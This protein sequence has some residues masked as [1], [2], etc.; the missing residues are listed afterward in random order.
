MVCARTATY[1]CE[2]FDKPC[3]LARV[4]DGCGRLWN[5]HFDIACERDNPAG[6]GHR[7]VCND[8]RCLSGW[9]RLV[10]R[11]V[12][13]SLSNN[14]GQNELIAPLRKCSKC[15]ACDF[16]RVCARAR[17]SPLTHH[18]PFNVA[19][20]LADADASSPGSPLCVRR[21]SQGSQNH[22]RALPPQ[23][24]PTDRLTF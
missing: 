18:P 20:V 15:V 2:L 19:S 21:G 22:H 6:H 5:T 24:P 13:A 7:S 14:D 9:P 11:G 1:N 16:A 10:D 12:S 8:D 4:F 3:L 17:V 23:P